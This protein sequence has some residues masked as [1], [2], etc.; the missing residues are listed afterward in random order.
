MCLPNTPV[1]LSN[2]H[3]IGFQVYNNQFNKYRKVDAK[4]SE[5]ASLSRKEVTNNAG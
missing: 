1:L 4:D 2:T 3:E 5:L